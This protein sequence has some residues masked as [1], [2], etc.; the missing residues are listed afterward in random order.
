MKTNAKN[1]NEDPKYIKQEPSAKFPN[2]QPKKDAGQIVKMKGH[3]CEPRVFPT[4]LYPG[5]NAKDIMRR[6]TAAYGIK[7][8]STE[9]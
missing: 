6:Q 9:P 8:K 5:P 3:L 2:Q 1:S 4:Q 7:K